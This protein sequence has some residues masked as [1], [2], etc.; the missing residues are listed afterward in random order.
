MRILGIDTA[1]ATGSVGAVE[2]GRVAAERCWHAVSGHAERLPSVVQGVVADAGWSMASLDAV[3]VSI[4]PGSFTGLRIGL[5]LAKGLAFAGRLAVIPVPTLDALAAVA[6]AEAGELVCSMIDA[7]KSELYA[8]LYLATEDGGLESVA[9]TLLVGVDDLLS[10]VCRA[11]AAEH[12]R[13]VAAGHSRGVAAGHSRT[14]RRCRFLG[15]AVTSYGDQIEAALG[16]DA[17][18][19]PFTHYHAA[20]GVVATLGARQLEA[21]GTVP[22]AEVEPHYVRSAYV[23]VHRATK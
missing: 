15:D 20:G 19:L 11:A 2:D 12:S 16:P 1:T 18:V 5:G 9:E 13:G 21:H 6:D 17:L 10:R 3:A 23:Q 7:R 8:G 22:L 14:L 4:G